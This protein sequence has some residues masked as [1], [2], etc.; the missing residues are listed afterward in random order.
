MAL[1][2]YDLCAEDENRRFSPYCWRVKKALQHKEL[3]YETI[4]VP[5]TGI[6]QI[7]DN[8]QKT[9]PMLFDGQVSV[10]DS[11]AIALYLDKT[12]PDR[13]ALFDCDGSIA[14]S[15]FVEAWT[16]SA[17]HPGII[18]M[19]AMEIHDIIAEV[20]KTYFRKT[21]E[22][23]LKTTLEEMHRDRDR[24]R[25]DFWSRLLALDLMLR[26]QKFI[27]GNSPNFADYIVYGT[28]KWPAE[29]SDYDILPQKPRILDWYGQLDA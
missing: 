26:Q 12:Y 13:P 1:K 15:R 22:A 6:G 14:V 3:E 20:D 17:L 7:K 23:E 25:A 16:Y 18:R 10:T 8:S 19:V 2:L 11:F 24:H 27:G 4:A 9:V 21:R 28:L 5:F 29:C